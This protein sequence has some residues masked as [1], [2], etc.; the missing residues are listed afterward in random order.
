MM[1][2]QLK[3]D[4]EEYDRANP[5]IYLA[6]ESVARAMKAKRVYFGAKAIMEIV[7]WNTLQ[8]GNDQF[9][10]NNNYTA[11]YARKFEGL[12]PDCVGFF[13]KRVV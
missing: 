5:G 10:I 12:N 7:R 9:K 1:T 11:Y 3:I 8:S 6:F 4:F 13:Q 2:D